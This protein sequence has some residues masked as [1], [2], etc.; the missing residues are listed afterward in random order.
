MSTR[1]RIRIAVVGLN[2]GQWILEQIAGSAASP[3]LELAA[4]CDLDAGKAHATAGKYNVKACTDLDALL[5]DAS[6]PAI[7]LFTG[8][9]GRANLIR[10]IIRAGKDVLTT[11]P[12]ERDPA[13]ALEVLREAQRL[14]RVV[15]MN[16]PGPLPPPDIALIRQWQG[17]HRLGAPVAARIE[18]WASYREQPNG[19]WYDDP[20]L[21]PVPPIFRLGI[22]LINDL[23]AVL[24]EAQKVVMLES[25]LFTGRPTADNGQLGILFRNGALANVF[26]SF[27]VG[28]GD[29]YRNGLTLNFE[30]GTIYRDVGA[31]RPDAPS[32]LNLVMNVN[33]KRACVEHAELVQHSGE[34]QWENFWRALNGAKLE[35]EILPEQIV[36]GLSV[37]EAMAKAAQSGGAA[38]VLMVK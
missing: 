4:V 24:G 22:Y 7:G 14:G 1:Q 8:P 38:E 19:S 23:V 20:R 34:Y 2:F 29:Y 10:K 16:S 18:T 5:A 28:D 33:G 37:I 13:A 36:M 21:C 12:F 15:H 26:A 11:K 31:A 30:R 35:G 25:R 17:Q 3:W 32:D 27:C 9:A 6:I